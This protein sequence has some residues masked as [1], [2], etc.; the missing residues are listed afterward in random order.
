MSFGTDRLLPILVA[1]SFAAGLNVYATVATLGLLGRFGVFVLPAEL[2]LL[3]SNFVIGASLAFFAIELV[4]DKIP[5][6]D[7]VWNTVHTFIR[8]P[9]AALVAYRATAHLSPA[10]Q[11]AATLLGAALA[12]A[13][14]GGK[15]AARAAVTASP[16][17]FTNIGLS[18]GED[19]LAVWLTWFAVRHPWMAATVALAFTIAIATLVRGMFR[20]VRALLGARSH[21]WSG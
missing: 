17:P 20:R 12:L 10:V 7:L 16:E 14:H 21:A 11:A 19:A 18:L 15:T 3:S 5:Y 13:A 8:V 4:A 9:V 1:V 6:F 2:H